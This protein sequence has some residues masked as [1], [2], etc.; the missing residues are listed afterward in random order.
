[1][2]KRNIVVTPALP[3]AN[4]PLHI[5]HLLEHTQANIWYLFQKLRGHNCKFICGSD[6][7]GTP[8]MLAARKQKI[9]EDK[10]VENM[11]LNHIKDL[12]DFGIYYD[13][14][15]STHTETHKKYVYEFYEQIKKSD[16]IDVRTIDQLYSEN[17]GMFLPDRYIKGTCPKCKSEN[18]NGDNCD[19][20]GATYSP[21]DMINPRSAESGEELVIR[22][23]EHVFFKLN[24]YKDFLT[25][26]LPEHTNKETHNKVKEWFNDDLKDW[27]ISRD[28]PYFGFEIPDKPGKY[29]YVWADAPIGYLSATAEACAESGENVDDFWRNP[30]AEIYHFIGKD[31]VNFHCLFWP[32]FLSCTDFNLPNRIFVHGFLN[33]NNEKMSK[34]KGTSFN[35]RSYINHLDPSYIR[36][37]FAT[38]LSSKPNDIE[39]NLDDFSQRVNSDLVGK[40]INLGSRGAQ[41]LHKNFEGTCGKIDSEAQSIID[42]F[43]NSADNIAELYEACEYSKVTT[44]IREFTDKANQYFDSLEPWKLVKTDPERVQNILTSILSIFRSAVIYLAPVLPVLAKDTATLFNEGEFTWDSLN[45][46][47]EGAKLQPYKHLM[48][49]IDKKQIEAI[50]ADMAP[51]QPKPEKPKKKKSETPKEI[52][53]DDFIKVDLRVAEIVEA[54]E[55]EGA[56]KLLQLTLNVGEDTKNVFAGIKSAYKPEDLKGKLVAMVYNL[57]PRKMKFGMSEGMVLAAGPGGKDLFVL[58]P[59]SGAKPGQ[60][61]K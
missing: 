9:A 46:S 37:Y 54:K 21:M 23:S 40:L 13:K 17:E 47:I 16:A 36:Y 3:Y 49:R 50:K 58:T 57:K 39:F 29:F 42:D 44:L 34:S 51:S 35:I 22:Q 30:E 43:K 25:K 27:D 8:I 55:V 26:W 5:G 18:Q 14:F 53:I 4:A 61:I 2:K 32:A 24:Q 15:S 48:K 45:K 41:M 56:D 12:N 60:K 7:H 52:T 20:C 6:S 1:M 33:T 10:F 11:R 31:I 38:K 28:N 19:S 59:D